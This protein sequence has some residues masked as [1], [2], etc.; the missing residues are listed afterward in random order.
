MR[1]FESMLPAKQQM[2]LFDKNFNFF[3][4]LS[5]NFELEIFADKIHH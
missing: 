3:H 1:S 2:S 4:V 5:A